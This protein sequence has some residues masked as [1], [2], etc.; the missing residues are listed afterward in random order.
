MNTHQMRV[1]K[2]RK[3]E[4]V[5]LQSDKAKDEYEPVRS[6]GGLLPR[7]FY[8]IVGTVAVRGRYVIIVG[9]AALFIAAC[10]AASQLEPADAP[11]SLV[12]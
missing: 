5:Q 7:F 8:N 6:A 12:R 10:I 4:N 11:P 1:S 9:S 2:G 3:S